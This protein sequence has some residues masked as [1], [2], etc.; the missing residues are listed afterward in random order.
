MSKIELRSISDCF[1]AKAIRRPIKHNGVT[2]QNVVTEPCDVPEHC[3]VLEHDGVQE[4]DGAPAHYD[5]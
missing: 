3:D 5:S 1:E 2:Y 4:H